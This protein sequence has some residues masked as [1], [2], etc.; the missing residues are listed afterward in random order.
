[1]KVGVSARML[2]PTGLEGI[3]RYTFETV[4]MMAKS[5]PEVDFILFFDRPFDKRYL[6]Y[7]NMKGVTIFLPTRLPFLLWIWLEILLPFYLWAYKID[8]LY[9]PDNFLSRST[10][11]PTLLVCHDIVYFHHPESI[12]KRWLTYYQKN[13][14]LYVTKASK[15]VSVS[16]FVKDDL[17]SSLGV[18]S[19]KIE[20]V[21]NALPNRVETVLKSEYIFDF[22]YFV[23]IGSIHPR[24]NII[25]LIKAFELFKKSNKSSTKLILV[26]RMAW[27]TNDILEN[28]S[29]NSD[30][31]Q[32]DNV[33]DDQ[34]YG[35]IRNSLGLIYV[36]NFEG[37]G[38][39]ILEGFHCEVPVITSNVTSMPEVAG[40]AAILVDPTNIE[41]ISKA[42]Y[43]IATDLEFS[44]Y[45]VSEGKKRLQTYEWEKSANQIFSSLQHLDN[46]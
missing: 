24:K 6:P 3:G 19:A 26:G 2:L 20:V 39:P 17:I 41:E 31:L 23:Y 32:L 16:Q 7:S 15:I 30:I 8:V 13:M 45:L 29:G 25:N 27:N 1:M 14:P 4:C 10:K 46:N 22:D 40:N 38:I 12:N 21:Y 35:L 33:K 18:N 11:V 42:F 9:A 34:V 44:Q 36:S 37:F 28:I 5:H 43:R